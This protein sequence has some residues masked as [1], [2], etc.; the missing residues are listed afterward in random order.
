MCELLGLIILV[1]LISYILFFQCNLTE[2]FSA[3]DTKCMAGLWAALLNERRVAVVASKPSRLS[4]CVQAANAT[5]FPMSWQ[6]I[7]I[8][9]L[10]KHLVDYLLAPMPFLIG[11]P[12]TVMEVHFSHIISAICFI[13]FI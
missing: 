8:P 3:M 6:H 13:K 4:A 10:P 7:F 1:L 2:Y 12:R 9:I 11:V 5:L